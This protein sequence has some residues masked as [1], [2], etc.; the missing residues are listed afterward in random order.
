M[1]WNP[2]ME[3][4]TKRADAGYLNINSAFILVNVLSFHQ[5]T[6][7][8]PLW[9]EGV[10]RGNLC[11]Q[12][13][14]RNCRSLDWLG[15][16]MPFLI[17]S[18]LRMQAGGRNTVHSGG[19]FSVQYSFACASAADLTRMFQL[20]LTR[21]IQHVLLLLASSLLWFLGGR[22]STTCWSH[23]T[24]SLP[25]SK[26]VALWKP[27]QFAHTARHVIGATFCLAGSTAT[28]VGRIGCVWFARG[29]PPSSSPFE[30]EKTSCSRNMGKRFGRQSPVYLP[31]AWP[32]GQLLVDWWQRRQELL[33]HFLLH[34][35]W[36]PGDWQWSRLTREPLCSW[37][38]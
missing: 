12:I 31:E 22:I 23:G 24:K 30:L 1:L 21:R 7:M 25:E 32:N 26:H 6:S 29:M 5:A 17:V 36:F 18:A 9:G 35:F 20:D 10:A 33:L 37:A 27:G 16:E 13:G 2:M 14:F 34:K 38:S 8:R 4:Y 11:S 28:W 19:H 3:V 15:F